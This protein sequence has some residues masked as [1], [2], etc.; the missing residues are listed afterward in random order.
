MLCL[1]E[2][3]ALQEQVVL[4]FGERKLQRNK[5][6]IAIFKINTISSQI[7]VCVWVDCFETDEKSLAGPINNT[8]SDQL[9]Q[10]HQEVLIPKPQ[11]LKQIFNHTTQ[12]QHELVVKITDFE[13]DCV[14]SNPSLCHI[15]Y[16]TGRRGVSH[17]FCFGFICKFSTSQGDCEN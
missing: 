17:L 6:C 2:R 5:P 10:I 16:V 13:P 15:N 9:A 7:H 11:V 8:W 1:G 14:G 4:S 12:Q 3:L